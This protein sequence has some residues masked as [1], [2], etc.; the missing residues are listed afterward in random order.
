MKSALIG[1]LALL[2]LHYYLF[3][4]FAST[5]VFTFLDLFVYP[6]YEVYLYGYAYLGFRRG[7]QLLYDFAY[8]LLLV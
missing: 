1:F 4:G 8:G 7:L 2:G 5:S 6:L 3:Y